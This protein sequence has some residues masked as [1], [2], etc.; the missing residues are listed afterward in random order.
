MLLKLWGPSSPPHSQEDLASYFIK[1][2]LSCW[3]WLPNTF[4]LFLVTKDLYS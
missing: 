1:S 4:P 2:K 3:N